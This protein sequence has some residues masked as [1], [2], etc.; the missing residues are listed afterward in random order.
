MG[1]YLKIL[2]LGGLNQAK[3]NILEWSSKNLD[4]N[5]TENMCLIHARKPT[6]LV[7]FDQFCQQ[8]A[9]CW[10]NS[11]KK[12]A[13]EYYLWFCTCLL[14]VY[15]NIYLGL[16]SSLQSSSAIW[17]SCVFGVV[18]LIR[19]VGV[20]EHPW[21]VINS[22]ARVLPYPITWLALRQQEDQS[23]RQKTMK[24]HSISNQF[25]WSCDVLFR[26]NIS[27]IVV[28]QYEMNGDR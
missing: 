16:F 14:Q 18:Q 2:I 4:F 1:V 12:H 21:T 27:L 10:W 22:S 20:F 17:I 25:P 26:C 13:T 6:H 24:N 23:F 11:L 15:V 3:L 9:C 5:P 28:L 8:K 7:E 19:T